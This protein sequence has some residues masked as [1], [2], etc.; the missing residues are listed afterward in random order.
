MCHTFQKVSTNLGNFLANYLHIIKY[1]KL[2]NKGLLL[3][4]EYIYIAVLLIY[5]KYFSTSSTS[6]FHKLPLAALV[7]SQR[8]PVHSFTLTQNTDRVQGKKLSPRE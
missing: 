1:G 7:V 5:V 2:L 3:T 6:A 4:T 8:R